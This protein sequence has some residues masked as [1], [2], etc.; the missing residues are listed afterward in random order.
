M[1]RISSRL[2]AN[3]I[4]AAARAVLSIMAASYI[5]IMDIALMNMF[6]VR[7]S[8]ETS[9][10]TGF[11]WIAFFAGIV[12]RL[13]KATNITVAFVILADIFLVVVLIFQCDV[14]SGDFL[15][16]LSEPSIIINTIAISILAWD[17]GVRLKSNHSV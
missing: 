10:L 13:W 2:N 3:L 15:E 8:A 6:Q 7:I 9:R 12:A 17:W 16:L 5:L 4:I 11:V 14:V 1:I